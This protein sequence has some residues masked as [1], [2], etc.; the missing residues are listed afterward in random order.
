MLPSELS[1]GTGKRGSLFLLGSR[2]IRLDHI[3]FCAS[4][5][6]FTD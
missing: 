3:L 2:W 4:R 1:P 5:L 6:R